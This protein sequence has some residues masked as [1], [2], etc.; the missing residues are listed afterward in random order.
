M[1][2]HALAKVPRNLDRVHYLRHIDLGA[3]PLNVSLP[4]LSSKCPVS[5]TTE[6]APVSISLGVI[7]S[8]PAKFERLLLPEPDHGLRLR[9]E[10]KSNIRILKDRLQEL[11]DKYLIEPSEVVPNSTVRCWVKEVREVSYDIDDFLDNFIHRLHRTAADNKKNLHGKIASFREGLIRSRWVADE[12]SRFTARLEEAI[13]RH[14]RY[15]LGKLRSRP[16][17]NDSV[18]PQI[19]LLYGK[20]AR[21]V[22]IESS[23][24]KLEDWLADD[25]EQS[26]RVV[27]IVGLGGIGKTTLAKE[28]YCKVRRRF[29]CWAFAR[30]SQQPDTRGLLSSILLQVRRHQ[31]LNDL[32]L[33]NLTDTIR[34][35]LQHKKYFII[36]DDLWEASI[37]YKEGHIIWKDD[38]V[39][40]WITEGF[41]CVRGAE[42]MEE[43]AESYFDELVNGGIIQPVGIN[44]NGE[45]LSGTVHD[46]VLNVIRYR[47]IEENF[48]TAIDHCQTNTRLA[49][50][51]RRLSL[52][53]GD[54]DDAEPPSKLR[55]SHVRS[56]VFFGFFKSLPSIVELRLLRVLILHLWGNRD[57]ISLDLT[58][59]CKFFRLRYLDISCNA[60]LNLQIHMQGLEYLDTLKIDSKV[61]AVPQD[62]V[63]L[64]SLLH[65]SL[66]GDI[67]L[68]IGIGQMVSLRSLRYF[69]LSINSGDVVQSLGKL[70]SVRDLH[71]TCSTISCDN[72]EENVGY[73]A[74]LLWKLTNLK[75]LNLSPG[76]PNNPNALEGSAS[77]N[78]IYFDAL[79]NVSS[80][81]ALLEKLEF[82]PRICIFSGL[83]RWIG[84]LANL[85]VTKIAVR[86]LWQRDI[87]VLSRL[88]ALSALSLYVRTDPA[89]RIVFHKEGFKFLNYFKFICR[90]LSIAFKKEAM[91]SVRRLKLGFSASA[92]EQC[93][94]VGAGF[95]NLENLDVSTANVG[96]EFS[97]EL[98]RKLKAVESALEDTFR[99][100]GSHPII[101]V[102]L[103]NR[104]FYGDD[105]MR[106][107][108][109]PE[110]HDVVTERASEEPYITGEGMSASRTSTYAST[111]KL[112]THS[113]S[114]Y[115]PSTTVSGVSMDDDYPEGQILA[116]PNLKIYTLAELKSATRSFR[117]EG[118]LGEGGFGRVYKGWVDETTLNPSKSN[119]GMVVAVKKLNR[120]SIGEMKHYWKPRANFLGRISHPNLVKLLGYCMDDNEVLLVHEFMAKGSLE[121]HLFRSPHSLCQLHLHSL[122]PGGTV[123]PLPWSLRL[124]ILTGAARGLAFLHSS[125]RSIIYR[126]FK[127]SNILL[128][129]HFN[130]KLS[131]FGLAKNS[132]DGEESQ[133]TTRLMRT[134]G[135]AGPEYVSTGH[136]YVK[137]D[138]YGFGVVLLEMISG[139]RAL[140]PNRP[141][142]NLVDW[143]KP[144]LANQRKVSR[145]MDSGLEGQYNFK[146]AMLACQ[147]TLKCLNSDPKSRPSMKEVVELLE[148]IE[149][150]K[151]RAMSDSSR[152]NSSAQRVC[153]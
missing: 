13:Q 44:Y 91:P 34:A 125:E 23:I 116:S 103:V 152:K 108:M 12:T 28:L 78:N 66:P 88:N 57:N 33:G 50:K 150:M 101:N 54:V 119:T 56:L 95:E 29:D 127:A 109:T 145:L 68:P 129:S 24:K 22:G 82:S 41:L 72:L 11:I 131:D 84:E 120:E 59:V 140:D 9:E 114:M 90:A 115:I 86:E 142:R 123:E 30:S 16:I 87:D 47:S 5:E 133:V 38:L 20:S 130:A 73:L 139:L 110:K 46:M 49:D 62:I 6:E 61:T 69:D 107:I 15:T 51:I 75:S 135:Y 153:A 144:L 40:Q 146:A 58:T 71:L 31:P 19:P 124:K 126:D 74:S 141:N 36:I 3:E 1:S 104:T 77:R 102:Q 106:T 63:L 143:A 98:V 89:E 8:L 105:E 37:M 85:S 76:V 17:L 113:T 100:C 92:L 112:S 42:H 64:P 118:V 45:V 138:V 94:L 70:K 25:G 93:S 60:T 52:H 137:T 21:L 81:P 111:G 83:P 134:Y 26:L 35:Y 128:D 132:L 32:E 121:N 2:T 99:M 148:Q 149:S 122:L 151:S 14:K 117:P 4:S 7:R 79:N 27:S 55:L 147:L 136:L 53:F 65:L 10:E 18:Q 97:N 67:N 80:P 96:A 43:V 48:V 39:K